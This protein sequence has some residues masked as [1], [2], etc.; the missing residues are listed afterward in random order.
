MIAWMIA[1]AVLTADEPPVQRGLQGPPPELHRSTPAVPQLLPV[2]GVSA[3]DRGL[4]VQLTPIG[5][6]STKADFT[7]AI[8]KSAER[9]TVL[10]ARRRA[11]TSPLACKDQPRTI[12]VSWTYA[13]L[14]LKPG[15]PF[16]LAN[17]LVKAP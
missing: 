12:L 6:N 9:P 14:G 5:C 7:V 3:D 13:D 4:T 2:Y 16:S 11:T 10:I 15:E 8:S 1:A 17:P